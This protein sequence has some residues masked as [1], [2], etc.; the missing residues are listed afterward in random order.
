MQKQETAVILYNSDKGVY[1]ASPFQGHYILP[2]FEPDNRSEHQTMSDILD[3]YNLTGKSIL[4]AV[5]FK[6]FP[7]KTEPVFLFLY[8]VKNNFSH[9]ELQERPI[10][11]NDLQTDLGMLCIAV[12]DAIQNKNEHEISIIHYQM[13][14]SNQCTDFKRKSINKS[15]L[16]RYI[17][18]HF[19]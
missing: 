6:H 9:P 1:F 10:T 11:K 14:N 12:Y 13:N 18:E 2:M 19:I 16:K 5:A 4:K 15:E 8:E 17:N 3:Y 7:E